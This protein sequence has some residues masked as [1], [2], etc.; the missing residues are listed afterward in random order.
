M[1]L[2]HCKKKLPNQMIYSIPQRRRI[3]SYCNCSDARA[4]TR[5]T[6][7]GLTDSTGCSRSNLD[8]ERHVIRF[9]SI[10]NVAKILKS[11]RFLSRRVVSK[12]I[13][14]HRETANAELHCA[15]WKNENSAEGH[16][17]RR[18]RVHLQHPMKYE[19][20]RGQKKGLGWRLWWCHGFNHRLNIF[21]ALQLCM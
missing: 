19:M 13:T 14:M 4:D 5:R 12:E 3:M 20:W 6:G 15:K 17:E 1:I 21:R 16:L 9:E 2:T 7:A 11:L 10:Q 8:T 18:E